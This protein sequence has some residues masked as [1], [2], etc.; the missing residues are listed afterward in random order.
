MKSLSYK[1]EFSPCNFTLLRPCMGYVLKRK[2]LAGW[3]ALSCSAYLVVP[4]TKWNIWGKK[5]VW[6]TLLQKTELCK[7]KKLLKINTM[8]FSKGNTQNVMLGLVNRRMEW[9]GSTSAEKCLL[10]T[11][12]RSHCGSL[13]KQWDAPF[14]L[15]MP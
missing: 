7:L 10:N 13:W 4:L 9:L 3:W 15:V 1:L 12:D 8:Q 14:S 11:V 6:E 2:I 5:R